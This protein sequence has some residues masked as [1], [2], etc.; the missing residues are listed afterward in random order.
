VPGVSSPESCDTTLGHIR[1]DHIGTLQEQSMSLGRGRLTR[2]LGL[3][4][5]L[6][7]ALGLTL[8]GVARLG[9]AAPAT[10]PPAPT[11]EVQ[12]APEPD[13][14]NV[15]RATLDNG[16]RVIIVQN[17]L[18]PVVATSVNYEVGSDDTTPGFPGTAH[19]L[20][21]MMFRGSPGLTAD[22][23]AQIGSIMGGNFNANTREN[24]TQYL[25]TVPAE[26]LDIA[27]HIEALRMSGLD[28]SQ[29]EWDNERG[30]IEQEVAQDLSSPNYM[31]FSK[32]REI[33]FAGTPYAH[34][35]LGTRP[36]FDATTADHLKR[37]YDAWYA[38]NNAI[39]V[40]VGDVDPQ[41]T[42]DEVKELFG[43]I[44]HKQI[45][46]HPQIKP[47]PIKPMTQPI[48]IPTDQP[49]GATVIA[50]RMPGLDSPDFPALEVL[51]DVLNNERGDLYALVPQGKALGT[52]FSLDPLP[53]VGMGY[54]VVAF[55]AGGD[56]KVA[57]KEI[58]DILGKIK[59]RGVDP[60][61]VAA[62][63]ISEERSA[64]F[65]KNSISGLASV[66]ADA[67]AVYG[68]RSPE[69]DLERI[70]KVTV[71]DVNRVARK[72]LD[73]QHS[74]VA[75]MVPKQGGRPT[76][77]G[78]GF[79]GQ[80]SIA[81]GEAQGTTLPDWAQSALA[82]QT[83]PPSTIH[84][85]T[86]TLPNGLTLIVQPEDV[87]DTVT[88][89]GH[90]KTRPEL[91]VPKGEE[92]LSQVLDD[93]FDYGTEH[94]DRIAFQKALDAIGASESAGTDF[95]VATLTRDFDRGVELL[96][97][98]ELHPAL[99]EM[100]M[101]IIKGQTARV[102]A[103]RMN[104]PGYH[105]EKSLRAALFPPDDPTQR[106]ATPES[107][108]SL[109]IGNIRDYYHEAFR[110]DLTSIVVIGK[111]TPE[112]AREVIAKY[113]GDWK[114]EGP[115]PAIDLPVVP[116]NKPDVVAVPDPTRVQDSVILAETLPI[117]RSSPEYYALQLGS[118]VLGG[119]FY[120]T[121]LSIDLRKN[122]GLV[123]SVG[124]DINAGR[125]RANYFVQ[126]ACDPDNVDKAN[127]LVV[128]ELEK[129]Q[130]EPV[131]ADELNRVKAL[132]LRQI[133]LG[134]S[135]IARIARGL[136]GRWDLDL[137][138]DEPTRA[139]ERYIALGPA[140][141]QAAFKKYIRPSDMVRISQG[142]APQ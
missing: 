71:A 141:I 124:N 142:P 125:T 41:K 19:A 22:Q 20:E 34:D 55:P 15:T 35:A 74:V 116:P 66:W 57:E 122:A 77:G 86:M 1:H 70:R 9:Y 5:A 102:V 117:N 101:E 52:G 134:E 21:H 105:V 24:L 132:M 10:R 131:G 83:V 60:D 87:S 118:A 91:V 95:S 135:S 63:K 139:A 99:P 53:K 121:R 89:Y 58:R 6:A 92:G 59:R 45:P 36:S 104:T 119:S 94:L 12:P 68:L 18:A 114:A 82:R 13:E 126:Y 37:F 127:Q 88:V 16:L 113:F 109:T 4:T 84:P 111:V 56:A 50:M 46:A 103:A 136:S 62:A 49:S 39:L 38:P 17:K 100:Q 47:E 123:Y 32:L 2:R 42:L 8:C 48:D 40:I 67:V 25:F 23:L 11:A 3:T 61:L 72:Y 107:V 93:L 110:P 7:A 73:F 81:L 44:P 26:D 69:E 115:K 30:A 130:D 80:E 97:D 75:V 128:Q 112:R 133:P 27:L 65:Q 138:L 98:N 76:A 90:I 120:S 78:G 29:K 31:L 43:P 129:M 106:D 85:T 54:T 79:G 64:E 96:A 28:A 14:A 137:P 51:S 140:D 108:R 33:M